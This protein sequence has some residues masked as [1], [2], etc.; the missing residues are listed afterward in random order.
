MAAPIFSGMAAFAD[1][2]GKAYGS[3]KRRLSDE[4]ER[5]AERAWRDEQREWQRSDRAKADKLSTEVADAGMQRTAMQGTVTESGGQK[6]FSADPGQAAQLKSMTEGIAELE[7]TGPVTQ[8]PG[9][10]ITGN[11]SKGHEIKA[12]PL[13]MSAVQKLNSPEAIAERQAQ[14]YNNNGRPLEANQMRVGAM[15]LELK[16]LGLNEAQAKWGDMQFDRLLK[17]KVPMG[18]GFGHAFA[19]VLTDTNVGGL[20]G[21][22]FEA[23]YA[24]GGKSFEIVATAPDGSKHSKGTFTDDDAGWAQAMQRANSAKL[25][26]KIG[27]VAE[28]L[29]AER[30]AKKLENDTRKVDILETKAEQE[31]KRIDALVA[32][33]IGPGRGSG[34]QAPSGYRVAAGGDRLEPIPGGPADPA[35]KTGTA[36]PMPATALKMQNEALDVIGIASSVQADLGAIEGQLKSGKLSFGPISNLANNA[37]NLAGMS[38][39]KSR[40]YSTFVSSLEKLRNDSLRLN[41]GVQT[42]GD[43]QRAWNELFQ[44]INDTKLVSQRLAEIKQ[45]NA[46][47]VDLRKRQVEDIRNNYGQPEYDFTTQTGVS[48]AIALPKGSSAGSA[49]AAVPTYANPADAMKLPPGTLFIDAA[50]VTRR[51]P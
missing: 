23:V 18:P 14:A 24:P 45:I 47:A 4:E 31:G 7:G 42:D 32:G 21:V 43:A 25:E 26:T 13:D 33:V 11:M 39:E 27:Y 5:K 2:F 48:N 34:S 36:K 37:K 44:N 41:T 15:D 3:E 46:R 50:G 10:A 17:D 28:A 12:G 20:A 6:L 22:K 16:R 35:V 9:A 29:K 8:Q 38:D 49:G 30:E 51:R 19:K 1:N 40:N